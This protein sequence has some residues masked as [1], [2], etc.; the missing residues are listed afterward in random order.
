M[1]LWQEEEPQHSHIAFRVGLTGSKISTDIDSQKWTYHLVT[2]FTWSHTIRF[3]LLQDH[4]EGAVYIPL[5]FQILSE[6][7]AR[8]WAFQN[9]FSPANLTNVWTTLKYK[10]DVSRDT[11]DTLTNIC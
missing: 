1:L 6:L 8:S 9:T 4:V 3:L 11:H 2:S 5:Q 7:S 10:Y